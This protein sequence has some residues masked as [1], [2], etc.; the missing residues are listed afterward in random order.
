MDPETIA[1]AAETIREL[2]NAVDETLIA[3]EAERPWQPVDDSPPPESGS[4]VI[5]PVGC[6]F[7]P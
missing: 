2:R 7:E 5:A 3:L 4:F 6:R 1:H